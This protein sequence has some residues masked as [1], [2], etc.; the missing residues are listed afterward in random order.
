L[1]NKEGAP[2]RQA[3]TAQE[4]FN[5]G[6]LSSALE[7]TGAEVRSKPADQKK[8]TF[9]FELLCFAGELERAGKQLEVIAQQG[10]DADL[11]VQGYRNALQAETARRQVFSDNRI[12][13]FPK[14]IPTYAALHLKA[15]H[16]LRDGQTSEARPLLEEASGSYPSLRGQLNGLPFESL[17]DCDDLLGPFLEVLVGSNYCWIPWES[18]QSVSIVEPKYLR[19]LIWIPASIELTFGP[20][21]EVLLPCLYPGSHLSPDDQIKLGRLTDWRSDVEGLSLGLG[22]KLLTA[23]DQEF[24]LAEI[25]QIEFEATG[26]EDATTED[27]A[28]EEGGSTKV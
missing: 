17:S 16:C 27:A 28:T 2:I 3:M 6:D 5:A 1:P 13:G 4:S 8:R 20:L 11:A 26:G 19:D 22:Q 14:E 9:L 24:P 21:G 7:A 25:R 15:I 10:A 12:P 18:I 23:D